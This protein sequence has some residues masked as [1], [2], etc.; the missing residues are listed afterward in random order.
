MD[1]RN[2]QNNN[3]TMEGRFVDKDGV[4]HGD[5]AFHEE[6]MGFAE[7][8]AESLERVGDNVAAFEES[9]AQMIAK[10][11]PE[12]GIKA[13]RQLVAR[14]SDH[15]RVAAWKEHIASLQSDT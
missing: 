8:E 10:L 5:E 3:R 14:H 2:D 7:E 15:E 9:Q 4:D 12:L 11:F 6:G 1:E 13:Y